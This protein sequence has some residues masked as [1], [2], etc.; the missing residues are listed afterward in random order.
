MTQVPSKPTFVLEMANN[1]MGD[2]DHGLR[3]IRA[4]AAVCKNFP[5]FAFGFK[6]QYRQLDTLIHPDFRNRMDIKYIQRFSQTALS[7][8]DLRKLVAEIKAH[9]FIAICTPFDEASVDRIVADGFDVLKIASCSFTDWPLLER[10]GQV[11]K[12]VIASVGGIEAVDID[13]VVSFFKNRKR[14][15]TLLHCVA[16]YPA[17]DDRLQVNQIDFLRR[18]YPDITIGFS[19][20]E[21]PDAT[22]PVA[23]A[24]GKGCRL[25]EKHVGLPTDSYAVNAYSATPEQVRGWLQAAAQAFAICGVVDARMEPS[26]EELASLFSLRRGVYAVRDIAAG[27]RLTNKDVQFAIP[28]Q[29]GHITAN[30]W[31]KYQYFY[32]TEA[33]P[34]G[35]PVLTTN[36]RRENVRGK[37][38]DIVRRVSDLLKAGN[39]VVP[40]EAVL[41]ISHHYGIDR[42]DEYGITM[43]TVVNRGYCK[44]LIAVL[45]GQKHPDQYH[46]RKEET[47]HVLHGTLIITLDGVTQECRPGS[48]VVVER[49]VH[50]A[51]ESATGAV[52]EEISSTHEIEDSFYADENIGKNP[53]RKTFLSYWMS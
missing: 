29:E 31:S 22:V 50:H 33:I 7:G 32:A 49:G 42:F 20:H 4:F 18:R 19:T 46:K 40:G 2:V 53:N 38:Y 36:T 24:V 3:L 35:K 34:A 16:E 47:F 28:T 23:I 25:F 44:K 26:R 21:R 13:A 17:P 48:V 11:D 8:D 6:M 14:D 52:F 51:F 15:L 45:P 1:H 5:Q 39:V 41:E 37:V 9:G 43:V 10:I 12:P 27:E 30:H